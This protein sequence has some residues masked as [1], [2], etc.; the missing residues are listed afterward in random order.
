MTTD[1]AKPECA[2]KH[3]DARECLLRRHPEIRRYSD[4]YPIAYDEFIDERCECGCHY[5]DQDEEENL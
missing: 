3:P 5:Q 4:D 2:C 1:E